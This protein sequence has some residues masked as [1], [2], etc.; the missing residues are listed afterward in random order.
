MDVLLR[1]KKLVISR[2]IAFTYKAQQERIADGLTVDDI[3]AVPSGK[4]KG[5]SCIL[6]K[7]PIT[8]VSGYTPRAPSGGWEHRRS[9]VS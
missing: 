9:S 8:M 7:A 1:I 5:K 2:K 3:I 6:S 4:A